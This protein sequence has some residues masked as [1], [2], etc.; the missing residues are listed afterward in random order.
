MIGKDPDTGKDCGQEEKG[1]AEDAM[2]K[3]HHR[4][5]GHEFEQTPGK[6]E[7]QGSLVYCSPQGCKELNMIQL[8]KN[9]NC[10]EYLKILLESQSCALMVFEYFKKRE[11]ERDAAWPGVSI[12]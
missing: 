12:P 3:Q 2:V 10:H 9:N 11:R 7:R 6:S 5:N 1:V 4:L 8:L